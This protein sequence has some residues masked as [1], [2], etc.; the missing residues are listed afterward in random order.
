MRPPRLLLTAAA[1]LAAAPLSAQVILEPERPEVGDGNYAIDLV[2][3]HARVDGQSSQVQLDQVFRNTGSGVLEARFLFP[4]PPD[5]AVRGLTLLVDGK[6]LTGKLMDANEARGTYEAIVRRQKDPALLEYAGRG[7]YRTSVF[8]IPAGAERTVQIKYSQL[9]PLRGGMV[10]LLLPVGTAGRT[11]GAAPNGL[12]RAKA[13]KKFTVDVR[14]AADSPVRTG[15][16][17]PTT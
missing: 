13:V 5:A 11:A 7:L 15:T 2:A 3:V 9:L 16:A 8:P 14:I 12:R 10:D 1:V 17:R 4:L 6:E